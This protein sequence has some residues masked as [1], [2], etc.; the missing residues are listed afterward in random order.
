MLCDDGAM[1]LSNNTACEPVALQSVCMGSV[2]CMH[3]CIREHSKT[4][5]ASF[6]LSWKDKLPSSLDVQKS[7]I[8]SISWAETML[9]YSTYYLSYKCIP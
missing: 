5:F 1:S 3:A 2:Y 9:V 7:L 8:H 6:V 4:N